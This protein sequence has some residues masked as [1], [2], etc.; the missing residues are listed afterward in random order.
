V[1]FRP[2]DQGGYPVG[3]QR[4]RG[5]DTHIAA[6]AAHGLGDTDLAATL[7]EIAEA[8]EREWLRCCGPKLTKA[9]RLRR[10]GNRRRLPG[11]IL[12]PRHKTGKLAFKPEEKNGRTSNEGDGR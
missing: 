9:L 12:S 8:A 10:P 7:I 6:A 3:P 5:C 4:D 2:C 1:A 11:A